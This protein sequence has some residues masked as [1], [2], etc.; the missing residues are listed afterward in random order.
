[1]K[2]MKDFYSLHAF[3]DGYENN[4]HN[5]QRDIKE[6]RQ[7]VEK[8]ADSSFWDWDNG[9]FPYFWRWQPEIKSDLRDGTSLWVYKDKLPKNTKRQRMPKN[10]EIIELM[11]EKILKVRRRNYISKWGTILNLSHYFPVPKG[12]TDIRMVYDLTESGLNAALGS[13]RFWMPTMLNIIDCAI[14]T[15]WF[16]DVDAGE[17]FSNFALDI[18]MRKYCGVDVSWMSK[19]G[20]KLWECWHR[21][22]MGMRP[23]PWVTIRLLMWMMEVVVGYRAE[24]TNP[25]RWD[26]IRL[27][28]PGDDNYNPTMHRVYKW[29]ELSQTLA[30]ECKFF[31]DDFRIIG[32]TEKATRAATHQLETTMAY[33]GVQDATRKR[34]KIT[35]TPGEWTGSIVL[36][37]EENGVFV[38]VS[39]KK[40]KRAQDI[41]SRWSDHFI[42]SSELPWLNY[43]ALES[44]IG[45]LIHLSM[46]YPV[47]K[48][49]LR[50]FYL[51][52]NSWRDG[53]D[54]YGWKIPDKA[55]KL[56]LQLGRR[57][58]DRRDDETSYMDV[59]STEDDAAAP[60][61][62]KAQPLMKEHMAI[63]VEMFSSKEPVLRLVRGSAILEALYIFGDA[64][65]LGFGSSWLSGSDI[66][67]RFGVWGSEA[68]TSTTSNYRELRNLVETLERSGL[69][70]EL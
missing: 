54:R 9:S 33:L 29:N 18:K 28:L 48:P 61:H 49:F 70:G 11:A 27:N 3:E 5:F 42:T 30:C 62:V 16:G 4:S 65:W 20:T 52:L 10:L 44:D 21:M 46:S 64:S 15:S 24:K 63:L 23:S 34:R 6:G 50:G 40:W 31:C 68:K 43:K 32:P 51:T 8:A 7:A 60:T 25:F 26:C 2:Y 35:Q 19:D 13:P 37:V 36:A 66:K 57:S 56:F 58:G 59:A 53:R 22:A 67:Y 17:M 41:V 38:T 1:M 45:F 39:K 69:N 12:E 55:Y 14:H 47:I